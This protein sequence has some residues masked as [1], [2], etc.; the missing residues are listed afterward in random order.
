MSF[1]SV[2]LHKRKAPLAA[3]A[4]DIFDQRRLA[5]QKA[6]ADTHSSVTSAVRSSVDTASCHGA[7]GSLALPARS[8]GDR[9]Q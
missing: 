5:L 4:G 3:A 7:A 1:V 8:M 6:T 2:G 9:R